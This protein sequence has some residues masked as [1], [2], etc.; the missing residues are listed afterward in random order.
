[1]YRSMLGQA[2]P[3]VIHQRNEIILE[4]QHARLGAGSELVIS[5]G[6]V[7][8]TFNGITTALAMTTP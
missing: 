7:R 6:G 5:S 8:R 2:F 3:Q 4:H 1:M